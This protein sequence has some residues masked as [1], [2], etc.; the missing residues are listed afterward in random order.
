M[1]TGTVLL[2]TMILNESIALA[3]PLAVA[4]TY[5]RLASPVGPWGVPTAI[6]MIWEFLTELAKSVVKLKR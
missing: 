3:M 1:P 4:F 5:S 6:K 2:V